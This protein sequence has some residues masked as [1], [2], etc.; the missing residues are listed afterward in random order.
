MIPKKV[1]EAAGERITLGGYL[2][3]IGEYK[4]LEVYICEYNEVMT[5]GMPDVYLWDGSKV[6]IIGGE[7]ALEIMTSVS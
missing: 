7:E 6:E 4:G 1:I 5:I 3:K 2:V